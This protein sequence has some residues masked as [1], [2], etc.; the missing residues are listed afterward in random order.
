MTKAISQHKQ[1]AM[2]DKKPGYASGGFVKP[3]AKPAM[4]KTGIKDSPIEGIKR[5]NGIKGM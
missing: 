2:G 4:L 1:L 5:K 3:P